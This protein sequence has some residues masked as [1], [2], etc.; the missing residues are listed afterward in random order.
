MG[1]LNRLL[2][3]NELIST[4]EGEKLKKIINIDGK[5]MRGSESWENKALHIGSAYSKKDKICFVQSVVEE[6][7]NEIV[8]KIINKNGIYSVE[9]RYYITSINYQCQQVK[10]ISQQFAFLL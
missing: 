8:K 6:K 5:T 2:E 9:T 3:W 1:T 10:K 7:R 4:N